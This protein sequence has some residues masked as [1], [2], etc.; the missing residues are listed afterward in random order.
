MANEGGG[1]VGG[2]VLCASYNLFGPN[3]LQ[4]LSYRSFCPNSLILVAMEGLA[5]CYTKLVLVQPM[6]NQLGGENG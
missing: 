2:V 5:E 4:W 3:A 6:W 1:E